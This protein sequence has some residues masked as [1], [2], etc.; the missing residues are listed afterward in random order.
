MSTRPLARV[1][2][3]RGLEIALRIG[4]TLAAALLLAALYVLVRLTGGTPNPLVHLAYVAIIVAAVAAGPAGGLG[5]GIASGLLLGPLMPDSTAASA[6]I[7]ARWGWAVRMAVYVLAGVLVAAAWSWARRLGHVEAAR[8]AMRDILNRVGRERTSLAG[9]QRLLAEIARWRPTLAAS[10]YVLEAHGR[11]YL[12]AG[13]S[14]PGLTVRRTGQLDG[15][16]AALLRQTAAGGIGRRPIRAELLPAPVTAELERHGGRSEIVVPLRLDATP[17]GVMFI[18]GSEPPRP[19]SD[20]ERQALSE[21]AAGAAALVRRAQQEEDRTSRRAADLVRP[22]LAEPERLTPIFQPIVSVAGGTTAGYEA[23]ARFAVDP[24]EPPHLWFERA[25]LAGLSAELQALAVRRA[26]E[27]AAAQRLPTG[28]FLSV[29]VS[30]SLLGSP[31]VAD[32]LGGDLGSL[33]IE[34]T[35]EEAIG[36]YDTLRAEMGELRARGARFAIDDAGAGYASLRHVTELRPDFIKLDARL[37]VGLAGDDGRQALV[38]AMQTFAHDI[39]AAL[40]AEGVETSDELELLVATDRPILV[41]GYA[42]ARPGAP[43]P[44]ISALPRSARST[45]AARRQGRDRGPTGARLRGRTAAS[46]GIAG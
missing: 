46:K 31:H 16:G 43:W 37:I 42:V 29:N 45:Q 34:L 12:L 26:R 10:V 2:S 33:V 30:P 19:L 22:I 5:F 39:G 11:A 40:I 23:L 7:L 4:G 15:V 32:A 41:Q 18:V 8:Q 28:S 38:R 9:C 14:A 27:V 21:L 44:A 36:D 17:V 3:G 1:A 13:W 25:A 6:T 20:L 24:P 35:E